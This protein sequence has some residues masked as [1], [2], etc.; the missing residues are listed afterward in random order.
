MTNGWHKLI[1]VLGV[2]MAL[3]STWSQGKHQI[4]CS[5]AAAGGY[6]AFPDVCRTKKG[7]LLCVFY[8]GY[9]HVSKPNEQWPNGGRV[10]AARST[11]NGKTWG[12]PSVVADTVHDDRDPHI[13]SLKDGT[14]IC[15]WFIAAN[16]SKP[17]SSKQPHAVFLSFSKDNG[18]TWSEPTAVKIDS[19]HWFA[20]SA[21]VRELPD[22]SLI[23]GLYTESQKAVFGATIK[24]DDKG[25]TWKD[26]A[27]IGEKSGLYLDAETD[28]IRLKDGTLLAALR[29]SKTD[30]YF[31]T[32]TD[33]GKT[34]S[35]VKSSGF[36]GHCPH[37]LRHTSGAILLTHRLPATALHW[38]FDEGKT[39]QGPLQIDTVGGAYPSCVE[40]PDGA[41]YCVY[42]EEGE[43]SSIRGVRLRV[44]KTGLRVEG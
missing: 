17:L 33:N 30:L 37:F 28:V 6:A 38:S 41:V 25:K 18:K 7:D 19:P 35:D 42:Y 26:L 22:G 10:M 21:P 44:S 39:W 12:A 3:N 2:L 11:D 31:A 16:P 34:W 24:S 9:G 29:S 20:C 23:L 4:V 1:L 27:P 43:G 13:A 5:G 14:L 15:N 8:S 40:L 36:K 32:S